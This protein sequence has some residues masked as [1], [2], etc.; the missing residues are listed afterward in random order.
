MLPLQ[1]LKQNA[2]VLIKDRFLTDAIAFRIRAK[3]GKIWRLTD[4]FKQLQDD[5]FDICQGLARSFEDTF[6]DIAGK[7]LDRIDWRMQAKTVKSDA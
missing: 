7:E 5:A 4:K 2:A 6:K 1:T 3:G